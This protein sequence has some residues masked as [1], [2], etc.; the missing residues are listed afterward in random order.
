MG[1]DAD[2]DAAGKIQ[3]GDAAGAGSERLGIFRI[4]AALD[5]VAGAG[6]GFNAGGE[7]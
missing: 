4:D 2:A 7:L 1:V 6:D 3:A 5:S